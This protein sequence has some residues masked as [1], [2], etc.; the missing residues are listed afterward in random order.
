MPKITSVEPQKKSASRRTKRFNV[1]LD[2][3]FAFGADED[4]IVDHRLIP[5]KEIDAS[6]LEKLL[7]EAEV[8]KLMERLYR[9]SGMRMHSEKEIRDYL[10]RLSFKRK[11]KEQDEISDIVI[12]Q[13]I[14]K[15]KV[16]GLID[17]ENF[18]SSWAESR[19]KKYGP[20]R[21]KQE[22]FKKGIKR[23]IIE[24]ILDKQIQGEGMEVAEKQIEKKIKLWK[25]LKPLDFKKKAYEYLIRRGFE[26]EIVKEVIEKQLQKMYNTNT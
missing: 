1:F 10:K 5:G 12:L 18:A 9:L 17:D 2:G 20:N 6:T 15:A 3:K 13:T 21:V 26:Y 11:I 24:T 4:L 19:L 25:N 23:E 14:E 22:L 8:G 7:Q 16:K